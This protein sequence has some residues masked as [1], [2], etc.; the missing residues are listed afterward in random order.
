[1]DFEEFNGLM[2]FF[3]AKELGDGLAFVSSPDVIIGG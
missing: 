2:M 3:S 1:M